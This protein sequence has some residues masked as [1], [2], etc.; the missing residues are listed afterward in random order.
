MIYDI[1]SKPNCRKHYN[2]KISITYIE[3]KRTKGLRKMESGIN[4]L[5][6]IRIEKKTTVTIP[7]LLM[8][9][10]EIIKSFKKM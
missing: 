3:P 7:N 6:N 9:F 4:E 1:K 8:S 10:T 5:T 2:N